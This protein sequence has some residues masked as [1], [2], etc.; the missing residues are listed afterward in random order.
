[1]T[2]TLPDDP[3]PSALARRASDSRWPML[4]L[5][6]A[7]PIPGFVW[8]SLNAHALGCSDA[9]RQTVLAAATAVALKLAAIAVLLGYADGALT[10]FFGDWTR[11][12]VRL[13][14]LALV[15]V[16]LAVALWMGMRQARAEQLRGLYGPPL[17]NGAG[18]F[19]AALGITFLAVPQVPY[20]RLVW[21]WVIL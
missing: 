13:T 16:Q 5:M 2:Y 20:L 4:T 8:L 10:P 21:G 18:V 7:G 1:M 17:G 6:L 11:L 3:R 15:A 19:A 12:G 9:W 14:L